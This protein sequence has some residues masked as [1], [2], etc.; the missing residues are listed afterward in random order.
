MA[1]LHFE[2][3][4]TSVGAWDNNIQFGELFVDIFIFDNMLL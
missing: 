4:Q 2:A 1:S 3:I